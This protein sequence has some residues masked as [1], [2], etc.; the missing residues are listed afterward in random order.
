MGVIYDVIGMFAGLALAERLMA[1]GRQAKALAVLQP[2]MTGHKQD[3][4]VTDR[5]MACLEAL[6]SWQELGAEVSWPMQY[7]E[8]YLFRT[9]M[10]CRYKLPDHAP[11]APD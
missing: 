10:N 2:L 11:H 1:S 4:L 6:G 5:Q 9:L 3:G 7:T 8:T